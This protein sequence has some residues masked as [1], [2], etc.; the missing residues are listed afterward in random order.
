MKKAI[1]IVAAVCLS[2]HGM[3]QDKYVTTAKEAL[4][5]QNLEE[6]KENIDKAM[7]SP[8][9]KEKPKAL[10]TKT[11]IYFSMQNAPKYQES[12]PYREGAQSLLRL[13]EVKPDYEKS[14]VDQLL[15]VTALLYYNDGAKAYNDKKYAEAEKYMRDIIRIR[16]MN[17]FDKLQDAYKKKFEESVADA[18]EVLAKSAYFQSRYEEAIPLLTK[19]KNN[20][21]TKTPS[22]YQCLIDALQRTNKNTEALAVIEE[23]LKTYPDDKV[24]KNY[25]LN[26]YISSGKQDEI[27]KKL[28]E[29]SAKDPNNAE[30]H[31]S[32]ATTYLG[33]ANPKDGK[34][35]ANA[36]EY[37]TKSDEAFQR[38]LKIAPEN[39][40]YNYNYGALYFN[41]ASDYNNQMTAITGS[42]DA[43]QNKYNKLKSDRDALF[44]KASPYFEKAYTYYSGKEKDL[45]EEDKN[46]YRNTMQAL[47]D[48]YSRLSKMD[49]YGEVKK[50]SDAFK[51]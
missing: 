28:E 8:E 21:L 47:M 37:M 48:I 1:L 51:S 20:P 19:V 13:V 33:M 7:L 50:R 17:R 45:K 34:K 12:N 38:S 35:P 24:I 26:Y 43:D 25:E 42:S 14:T 41:Q 2:L 46:T 39:P 11:Q 40:V 29:A 23:G 36:A 15:G 31:F 9:T 22:A 5:K 27:V 4:S 10:L 3:A 32:V 6:A 16:D 30:L 44:S 18:Y 49:K